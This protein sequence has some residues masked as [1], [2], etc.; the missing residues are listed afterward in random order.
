MGSA[1]LNDKTHLEET[2][3]LYQQYDVETSDTY[4]GPGEEDRDDH[5][6]FDQYS[7]EY[8]D[9]YDSHVV[10]AADNDSADDPFSI[11][12]CVIPQVYQVEFSC[13]LLSTLKH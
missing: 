7:D 11:R 5:Y 3:A 13:E 2:R 4:Q 12:R 10:G 1:L 6:E 8:D 9:T